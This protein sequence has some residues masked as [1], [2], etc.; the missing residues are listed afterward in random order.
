MNSRLQALRSFDY[1]FLLNRL[2]R[3]QTITYM[4]LGIKIG[5]WSTIVICVAFTAYSIVA[6]LLSSRTAALTIH[7]KIAELM[8]QISQ[9]KPPGPPIDNTPEILRRALFGPVGKAAP[10]S[11][12]PT[13]PPVPL[14]LSLIGTFVTT[15]EEPYAIIEDKK[16]ANQDMFLIGQNLFGQAKLKAIFQDRVEIERNG[17]VEILK[18]DDIGGASESSGGGGVTSAGTDEFV[19]DEAELDKALENLPLLLTQARAVPYFKEGRAVGLRM[20]AIKT[21]SLYEK[22]G[23]KNGDILK[24][25]N[26]QSLGDISQALK[27]IETLKQERSIGVTLEREKQDHE[28]KYQIR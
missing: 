9:A 23:F 1:Q 3:K 6:N 13:P 28:F 25:I 4:V 15:G 10:P 26:G 7:N 24:T 16:K 14:S 20:F 27:L 21:G 19:V 12:A 11:A 8:L 18:L 2:V 22:L 17:G 5:S